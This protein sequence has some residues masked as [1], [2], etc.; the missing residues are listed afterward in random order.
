MIRYYFRSV[1]EE[2][3]ARIEEPRPGTWVYVEDPSPTELETVAT[4]F[5]LDLDL[6][7]DAVDPYEV[8]RFE[9]EEGNAY[10]YVRFPDDITSDLSTASMLLVVTPTAVISIS[11]RHPDFL[12]SYLD[13]KVPLVTT[14][15]TKLFLQLINAINLHYRHHL[16]GIRRDVQR[17]RVNLRTIRNRD[18]VEL[19]MFESA[20]NDFVNA[21]TPMGTALKTILS[22]NYLQL[23]EDDRD[24]IEDTQLENQQLLESTKTTLKS[25]QNV[26]SAYTAIVTNNLNQ[27]I[28]FLAALTIIL[29]VPMIVASFYGMNV[30]LPFDHSPYAFAEIL[31][32][33][34]VAM[35]GTVYYFRKRDWL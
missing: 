10:F 6:L 13:G 4:A 27:V 22:G 8:P 33:T 26:R 17:N 5:A 3:L 16:I 31:V 9:Y 19:V 20:L 2:A 11:R 29:T 34:L 30:D 28:K 24:M 32:A 25:I 1:K 35:L 21:L 23:F 12:N 14:Q 7:K 18:I 15:R